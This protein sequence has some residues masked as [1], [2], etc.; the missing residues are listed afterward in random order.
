MLQIPNPSQT[1][2]GS[3]WAY[4]HLINVIFLRGGK[5]EDLDLYFSQCIN[6]YFS[7]ELVMI[8]SLH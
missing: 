5:E 2:N 3:G 6:L 7:L 8:K 1:L 4:S